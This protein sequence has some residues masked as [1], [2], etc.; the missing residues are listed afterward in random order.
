MKF[1]LKENIQKGGYE[2]TIRLILMDANV[3][4]N[5]ITILIDGFRTEDKVEYK[6]FEDFFGY[7][8]NKTLF[9]V[10]KWPSF[11]SLG[12]NFVEAK[13]RAKNCGAILAYI[14]ISKKFKDYQI[15]LVGF[16]LGNHVIKHCIKTLYDIYKTSKGTKFAN[17]K[18]IIF[19]AGATRIKS[20]SKWNDYIKNLIGGRVINCYSKKDNTLWGLYIPAM[21]KK[22][23]GL[24]PLMITDIENP[25]RQLFENYE[26]QFGHTEYNYK[27]VLSKIFGIY[28]DI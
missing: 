17:L 15:N 14:L 27:V 7:F 16:S 1:K 5:T 13:R 20:E 21:F 4:S 26:F 10:Y 9:Y 24:K 28:R 3:N 19:I 22:P 25:N 6:Q 23:I 8:N 12:W 11:G 2:E 18:N